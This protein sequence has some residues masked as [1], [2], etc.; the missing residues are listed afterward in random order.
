MSDIKLSESNSTPTNYKLKS[1]TGIAVL[2]IIIIG[3][4]LI[5]GGVLFSQLVPIYQSKN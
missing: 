3:C 4:V 5:L 1:Y 2:L